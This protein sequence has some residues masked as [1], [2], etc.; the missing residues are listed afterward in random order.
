M[1][2]FLSECTRSHNYYYLLAQKILND[3]FASALKLSFEEDE[4]WA[5]STHNL[6]C[7]DS[8]TAINCN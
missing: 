5:Y 1:P 6:E 4:N 8:Y 3:L 2:A 7:S